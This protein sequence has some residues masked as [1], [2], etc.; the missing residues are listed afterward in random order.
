[1]TDPSP[2]GSILDQDI[3]LTVEDLARLTRVSPHAIH[4]QRL[5]DQ[6]PGSLG[7]RVGAR[8]L[9]QPADIRAWLDKLQDEQRGHRKLEKAP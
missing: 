3:L 9:F 5:R 8:V 4:M 2:G 6:K 1:M 7:F